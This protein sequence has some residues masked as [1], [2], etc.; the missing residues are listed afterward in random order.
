MVVWRAMSNTSPIYC[1]IPSGSVLGHVL[2]ELY[3]TTCGSWDCYVPVPSCDLC[4]GGVS[5]MQISI[6]RVAK[7]K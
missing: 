5:V 2:F 4:F 1:G 6:I 7:N 3:G